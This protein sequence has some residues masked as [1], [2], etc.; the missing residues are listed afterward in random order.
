MADISA[1]PPERLRAL[2]EAVALAR[3][4]T[5]RPWTNIPG[6]TVW[7]D[8]KGNGYPRLPKVSLGCHETFELQEE[9]R[10]E[11]YLRGKE[12]RARWAH[13]GPEFVGGPITPICI[14]LAYL[15]AKGV[16]FN[17]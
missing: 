13:L 14:C 15:A 17:G 8:A 12:W 5:Q 11:V 2:D 1:W 6:I 4:W 3:G 16:P 7:V 10:I 9:A